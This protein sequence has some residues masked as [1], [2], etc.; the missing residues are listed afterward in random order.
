MIDLIIGG[1]GS[2]KSAYAE[3][4]L[5]DFDGIKFYIAT[6]QLCDQ[7]SREKAERHR[8]L[9]QGKGFM[10]IEQPVDLINAAYTMTSKLEADRIQA[11][12][13]SVHAD[14]SATGKVIRMGALLECM[15]NLTANEMFRDGHIADANRVLQKLILD[16]TC[17]SMQLQHLVIVSNNVFEDGISYD[18]STT[19]YLKALAMINCR[20]A[21]MAD[22]VTEV[23]VGIPIII[24][25]GESEC[26]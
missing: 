16:V 6:M 20:L 12:E 18:E 15:S 24:K 7:E 21:A 11:G 26:L 2:G 23:V 25:G 3:E 1:S 5:K 13:T 9:R 17:L 22:R 19:E 14:L 4:Q 10:T 8:L